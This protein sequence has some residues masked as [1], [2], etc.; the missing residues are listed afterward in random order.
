MKYLK[1]RKTS[2]SP[3][4]QRFDFLEMSLEEEETEI[5]DEK[6]VVQVASIIQLEE[7]TGISKIFLL[8]LHLK[9]CSMREEP[10][11][12]SKMPF[13]YYNYEK[14]V[15]GS[16]HR[17]VLLVDYIKCPA[18][19]VPE[20]CINDHTVEPSLSDVFKHRLLHIDYEFFDRGPQ[21]EIG[22]FLEDK[23]YTY[24]KRDDRLLPLLIHMQND[25]QQKLKALYEKLLPSFI[26]DH[27]NYN[28]LE[29][30]E[31][32]LSKENVLSDSDQESEISFTS[33]T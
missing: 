13:Y 26:T 4:S 3:Q 15:H 31:I 29:Q 17:Q 16:V 21:S 14:N 7:E 23:A 12:A 25:D 6:F 22:Q 30:S 24:K 32:S 2:I 27:F 19:V 20:S 33:N 9:R 5:S 8:V 10:K 11:Y 18:F 28:D 1:T